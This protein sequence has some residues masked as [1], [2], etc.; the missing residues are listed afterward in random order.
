MKKLCFGLL[1]VALVGCAAPHNPFFDHDPR[2][3][4]RIAAGW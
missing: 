4:A 3:Q 1:V 2:F